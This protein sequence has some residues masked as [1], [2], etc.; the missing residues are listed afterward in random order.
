[1]RVHSA[2]SLARI[3]PGHKRCGAIRSALDAAAG[4]VYLPRKFKSADLGDW[5][6]TVGVDVLR[7]EL[8]TEQWVRARRGRAGS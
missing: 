3:A 6:H 5:C 1:M 4:E 2:A 7:V 8:G